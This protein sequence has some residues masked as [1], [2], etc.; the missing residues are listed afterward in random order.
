MHS[1]IVTHSSHP[2]LKVFKSTLRSNAK[3]CETSHTCTAEFQRCHIRGILISQSLRYPILH[4]PKFCHLVHWFQNCFCFCFTTSPSHVGTFFGFDGNFNGK[5]AKINKLAKN[6][7]SGV[8]NGSQSVSM[9][10]LGGY[11]YWKVV[12]EFW[13]R[14]PKYHFWYPQNS[15]NDLF[16]NVVTI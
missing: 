13:F 1:S 9:G 6:Y 14:H 3:R 10:V 4:A 2:M 11:F 8:Q 16:C 5:M 7:F 12:I 15:Q